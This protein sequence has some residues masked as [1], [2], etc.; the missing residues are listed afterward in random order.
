MQTVYPMVMGREVMISTEHYLSASAGARIFARGGNA[1]D[2]AVAAVLVEGVVNPHMHTIGGEAPMLIYSA[3]A[4]R[5]IA[6]NGNMIAPARATIDHYRSLGL[7]L[8]PHSGLLAAGVPAASDA[9]V[10]ALAEF[11]TMSLA[12]VLEPAL[13]LAQEGFPMHVGLAGETPKDVDP[14]NAGAGASLRVF[15]KRFLTEWPSTGRVYLPDGEVPRSARSSRI[16]RSQNFS[17]GCSMRKR[18]RKIADARRRCARHRIVSIAATSRSISSRTRMRMADCCRPRISPHSRRASRRRSARIIAAP[19]FTNVVRGRR[20][21]CFCS[22]SKSSKASTS[23][24]WATTRRTTSTLSSRARSSHSP[25]AR[26]TTP[27][28]NSST[29][30]S[31]RWCRRSMATSA[32]HSSTR[33]ALRW[34]SAPAIRSRCVPLRESGAE[35]R[36]WGGGTI[37]VTACDRAGNMIAVTAS[38]GWIP[39]SPV[40]ECARLSARL[41]DANFFPRRAA[42]QRAQT[43]EASAHHAVALARDARWRAVPHLRHAGRRSAGSVDAAIFPQHDR[44]RDGIAAGD[45]GAEVFQRA[46]PLDVLPAWHAPGRAANRGAHR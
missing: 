34:S 7:K 5:V 15:A 29:C 28:R 40:I 23:L 33:I 22:S 14:Q 44:F 32:A 13:A 3:L 35:T 26:P 6:I 21:R 45:R 27:T 42:S 1:I 2:A 37:H 16:R 39:S 38:G 11:G 4:R 31:R 20:G 12:D 9:L 36:A 43:G 17:R 46:F 30:R 25:T 18:R 8:V 19:P 24:R 41:A 10:T